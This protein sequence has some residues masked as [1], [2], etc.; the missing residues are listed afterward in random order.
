[1]DSMGCC[2]SKKKN[3]SFGY[4]QLPDQHDQVYNDSF[5]LEKVITWG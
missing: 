2:Y 1:M 4:F 3:I 5:Q